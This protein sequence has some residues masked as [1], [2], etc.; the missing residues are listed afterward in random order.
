M[1]IFQMLK[2]SAYVATLITTL[3]L[4][5][6]A[7]QAAQNQSPLFLAKRTI[8]PGEKQEFRLMVDRSFDAAFVNMPVYVA[9]GL[10]AGHR[11][12][13]TAGIHGDEINGSEI[14][15]RTFAKI[16]PL[17]LRGTVIM[18]PMI[19][20]AGIRNGV[21]Y[22]PDRRDLN[23]YFPGSYNGSITSIV[24]RRTF[25]LIT[26]HCDTLIDLHTGSFQRANAPQI[27]VTSKNPAA[28]TL[29]RHFGSGIII[30]GGGPRGSLRR[31]AVEA[32]ITAIIYEAAGP[33]VFDVEAA[34][35]GVRGILNVMHHLEILP[36]DSPE[37]PEDKIYHLTVW[38]R[39]PLGAGGFFFPEVGLGTEVKT[40]QRLGYLVTPLE[41]KTTMLTASR[42]GIIIGMA[43][44]QI[45]LS[46]YALFHLGLRGEHS[47]LTEKELHEQESDDTLSDG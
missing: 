26:T 28:L 47:E 42:D 12:C 35:I 43:R 30:L 18:L 19:N 11:L 45:V 15:R 21:R 2:R 40:G 39:V 4:N 34:N 16:D 32:G 31:E 9:H 8:L 38:E 22:M 41:D 10:K 25:D 36:G 17:K 7:L 33:H 13:I 5:A 24:A 14:A 46:G 20:T 37:I 44:P 6:S 29:A 23:R 1:V 27:R 3:L